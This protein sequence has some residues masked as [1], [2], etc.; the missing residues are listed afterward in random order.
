MSFIVKFARLCV[1]AAATGVSLL[2]ILAFFGFASP[3]LDLINHAQLFLFF[4]TLISLLLAPALMGFGLFRRL[5]LAVTATAFLLS[6]LIVVPETVAAFAPRPPPSDGSR[7]VRVVTHNLFGMNYD[8]ARVAAEFRKADPDIIALQEYF[9][10]Q[11]EQLHELLIPDYPYF[12]LC[13]GERRANKRHLFATAVHRRARGQLRRNAGIGR[14]PEAHSG[15]LH[16]ARR[17]KLLGADHASGLAGTDLAPERR[18][19]RP[20][21]LHRRCSRA[22]GDGGRSQLDPMV[23]CTAAIL[24]SAL[25]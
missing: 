4:G 20:R 12:L 7:V 11:R 22:A 15:P 1:A 17:R 10:D 6:A 19:G 16:A 2:S 21:R 23:L 24:D 9:S 3:V 18:N 8:M 5:L 14:S 13:A 25:A